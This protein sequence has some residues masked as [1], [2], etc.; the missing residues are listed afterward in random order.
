VAINTRRELT[1]VNVKKPFATRA[2]DGETKEINGSKKTLAAT[3]GGSV[4]GI[5]G[6]TTAA[7]KLTATRAKETSWSAEVRKFNSRITQFDSRGVVL[8]GFSVD[9]PYERERGIRLDDDSLPSAELEFFG[10]GDPPPPPEFLHIEVTSCWSL[11]SGGRHRGP[12]RT[13]INCTIVLP[14]V[15]S[16]CIGGTNLPTLRIL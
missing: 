2:E 15:P 10:D 4:A 16:C 1:E 3:I 5:F 6:I 9:D 13:I 8:W 14:P 7:G 12:S 11:K